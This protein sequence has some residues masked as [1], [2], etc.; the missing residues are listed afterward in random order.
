MSLSFAQVQLAIYNWI[1]V[2]LKNQVPEDRIY[3]QEQGGGRPP[4]PALS[5]RVLAGPFQYGDDDIVAKEG[6]AGAFE[7]T[8]QRKLQVSL[9]AYGSDAFAIMGQLQQ[10]T[11]KPTTQQRVSK[12]GVA[13]LEYSEVRNVTVPL[14]TQFETRAQMDVEIGYVAAIDDDIGAIES[15][16]VNGIAITGP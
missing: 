15:S 2:E 5:M 7:V 14:E 10:S 9:N 6:E 12:L 8:G 13:F 1:K 3:W 4:S 16:V 11:Q